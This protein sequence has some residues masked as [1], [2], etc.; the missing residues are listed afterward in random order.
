MNTED[1]VEAPAV[2]ET[3]A[4]VVVEEPAPEVVIDDSVTLTKA[5]VDG[6]RREVAE[7]RRSAK[8]SE[9]DAAKANRARL[10]EE[11][12]FQTLAQQAEERA[13]VAEARAKN[14]EQRQTISMVAQ[15]LKFRDPQDAI[16]HLRDRGIE[17]DDE[18][19]VES[20]LQAL[21]T[22]KQYLIDTPQ[23]VKTGGSI[24]GD[25]SS[26]LTL[27]EL[28]AMSPQQISAL[29]QSEVNRVLSSQQ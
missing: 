28:K 20:A 21:A 4:P 1:A 17:A 23:V 7:S 24:S 12:Q 6:L 11:G 15:R 10:E 13:T 19:A 5:E 25:A 8:K 16:A 29:D 18:A 26:S 3:E 22:E 2:E 9:Q 14:L 27:D